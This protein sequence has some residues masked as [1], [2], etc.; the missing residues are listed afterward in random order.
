[1]FL[2]FTWQPLLK[3]PATPLYFNSG[4]SEGRGRLRKAES[5]VHEGAVSQ[6]ACLLTSSGVAPDTDDKLQK[7]KKKTSRSF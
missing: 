3:N 7:L 2:E 1:M 6:A 4:E 5:H